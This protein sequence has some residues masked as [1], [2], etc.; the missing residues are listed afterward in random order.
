VVVL[1][2]D[3]P[4]T[5]PQGGIPYAMAE[6]RAM[7]VSPGLKRKIERENALNLLGNRVRQ[8]ARGA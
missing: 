6:V 8:V 5:P 7:G 1:G 4:Y 3:H 2:G